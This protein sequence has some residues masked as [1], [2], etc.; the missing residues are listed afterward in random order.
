MGSFVK[1]LDVN[2]AG[3]VAVLKDPGVSA[4][5]ATHGEAMAQRVN[6][7]LRM[8]GNNYVL[9]HVTDSK[10]KNR[11]R[12]RVVLTYP[13]SENVNNLLLGSLR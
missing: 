11:A 2:S 6:G 3:A 9:V 10:G 8:L 5:L 7:A 13:V 1:R 4:N 12:T